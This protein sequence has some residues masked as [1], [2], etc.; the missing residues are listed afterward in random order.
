MLLNSAF[1]S[2]INNRCLSSIG[3]F[4]LSES[5]SKH[6]HSLDLSV[7]TKQ[8]SAVPMLKGKGFKGILLCICSS[9]F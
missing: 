4:S 3:K 6:F 9:G 2:S 8:P 1:P 5:S 7:F